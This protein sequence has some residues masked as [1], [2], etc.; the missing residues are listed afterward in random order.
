[1]NFIN[2]N[3]NNTYVRLLILDSLLL[4]KMNS[5]SMYYESESV[6]LNSEIRDLKRAF[7]EIARANAALRE[8]IYNNQ[9]EID[10]KNAEIEHN[11]KTLIWLRNM[12]LEIFLILNTPKKNS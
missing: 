4:T 3:N 10:S 7:I 12:E 6:K 1:M 11:K 5:E 2:L 8:E 9:V